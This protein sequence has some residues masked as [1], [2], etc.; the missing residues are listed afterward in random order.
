MFYYYCTRFTNAC[1][2]ARSSRAAA[3][4]VFG[5]WPPPSCSPGSPP[6]LGVLSRSSALYKVHTI[7]WEASISAQR[8]TARRPH[9]G[10]ARPHK[11]PGATPICTCVLLLLHMLHSHLCPGLQLTRGGS[12]RFW[13]LAPSPP[14]RQLLR[15]P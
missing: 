7:G 6:P 3:L 9:P 4:G 2:P 11:D 13:T 14:A 15:R 8:L 12:G 10:S 5:R 1:V